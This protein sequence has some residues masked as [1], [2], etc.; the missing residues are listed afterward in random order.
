[1]NKRL[2][3]LAAPLAVRQDG[4]NRI[5][6]LG[7]CAEEELLLCCA[8]TSRDDQVVERIHTL[9]KNHAI[10]WPFVLERAAHHRVIPV[11]HASL[12]QI[13]G[14]LVPQQY[15]SELWR[16][17]SAIARRNLFLT[18]E[19]TDLFNL[20]KDREIPA[21]PF[22][23]PLTALLAYGSLSL[24]QFGDLDIL[25]DPHD[26]SRSRDALLT[27]GFR[28]TK[29]FDWQSTFVDSS[30]RVPVDLH[31]ALAPLRFPFGVRARHLEDRLQTLRIGDCEVRTLGIEDTL[32][33]LCIQLARD[34]LSM[35][36]APLRLGKI[37]DIAELLRTQP[38][39]DW[40]FVRA[41]AR[42]LGCRRIVALGLSVATELAGAPVPAAAPIDSRDLGA[43][44][45]VKGHI[46]YNRL[47]TSARCARPEPLSADRFHFLAREH[48]RDKIYPLYC[49]L[50][51][52]LTPNEKDHALL[53]LPKALE[54]LYYGVKP[55]RVAKD[56][57]S[58]FVERRR[59]QRRGPDRES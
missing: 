29:N 21:I 37:C 32:I 53:A 57:L 47:Y 34:G 25:V 31:R 15:L 13:G 14:G 16:Y 36:S 24:R 11:V 2:V 3:N 48:W 20:F 18:A 54:F 17:R 26:Y 41:E 33:V 52:R 45:S 56:R 22:K 46:Y 12:R 49:S 7:I 6:P 50:R 35:E 51:A 39:I 8:R 38:R 1:V 30:G 4:D 27:H 55:L 59:N 28:L 43:L 19:L 23:G 9:L 40:K 42:R 58:S 10:D 5:G 44:Q